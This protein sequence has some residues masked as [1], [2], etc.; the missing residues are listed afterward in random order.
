MICEKCGSDVG[1]KY[2]DFSPP[3][4]EVKIIAPLCSECRATL[5]EG[6][7]LALVVKSSRMPNATLR[8][9]V[10]CIYDRCVRTTPFI[11]WSLWE[12][13]PKHVQDKV[14]SDYKQINI[15]WIEYEMEK[16]KAFW[17]A[18]SGNKVINYGVDIETVPAE[19]VFKNNDAVCFVYTK[20][21]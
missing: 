16:V 11:L 6:V 4:V 14:Y 19:R 20:N 17:I 7:A 21:N 18:I 3:D 5:W 15:N 13:M 12:R 1:V 9:M 2:F 10:K 8:R